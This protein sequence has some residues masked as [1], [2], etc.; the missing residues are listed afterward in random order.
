MEGLMQIFRHKIFGIPVSIIS[1]VIA[2]GIL[3]YVVKKMKATPDASAAGNATDTAGDVVDT[4]NAGPDA[5]PGD[6]TQ[7]PDFDA[8]PEATAPTS[9]VVNSQPATND[10]WQRMAVA[11]LMTQ[12]Y[13]LAISTDAISRYLNSEPMTA[14]QAQA[15]DK[16]IAQFGLPPESIPDVINKSPNPTGQTGGGPAVKQGTPPLN[17]I[18]KGKNDNTARELAYLY[19]GTNDSQ[20]VDRIQSVNLGVAEPY[21]IGTKVRVPSDAAPKYYD[22]TGACNT[23]FCI[24]RKNS[25]TPGAIETLNPH[26]SFP[27][28]V[29][30]RVRVR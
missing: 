5:G 27:V 8:I 24:A 1:V 3:Y 22:A 11:W 29:H 19:Y 9:G 6:F 7:Q 13:S 17:H 16:A 21:P 15:R 12:G 26:L 28:K 14:Q 18:V 4:T 20:S 2:G 23:Q 30:T 10:A 25:T